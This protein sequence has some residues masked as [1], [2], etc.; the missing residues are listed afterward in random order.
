MRRKTPYLKMG[1]F[2]TGEYY[3]A[4]ADYKRLIAIEDSIDVAMKALGSGVIN[5]WNVY[6]KSEHVGSRLLTLEKG[7]GVIPITIKDNIISNTPAPYYV[8]IGTKSDTDIGATNSVGLNR[9]SV[10]SVKVN[11]SYVATYKEIL[12]IP[13]PV[14]L[15]G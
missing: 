1:M 4:D 13:F 8:S 5:G 11:D 3:E 6:Q 9:T 15:I 2:S 12:N 10:I 14:G 7:I